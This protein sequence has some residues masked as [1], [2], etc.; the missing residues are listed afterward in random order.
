MHL[1]HFFGFA[2]GK[3]VA[4]K[5][6]NKVFDAEFDPWIPLEQERRLVRANERER[7]RMLRLQ[8]LLQARETSSRIE[9]KHHLRSTDGIVQIKELANEILKR[10]GKSSMQFF[11]AKKL[12]EKEIIRK[13]LSANRE[14]ELHDFTSKQP[15]PFKCASPDCAALFTTEA[16]DCD[17]APVGNPNAHRDCPVGFQKFHLILRYTG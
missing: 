5:K 17:H 12:A 15:P 7:Q 9:I 10:E 16:Q 1:S 2:F 6:R 11:S 14:L 13:C 4:K 8:A 3:L